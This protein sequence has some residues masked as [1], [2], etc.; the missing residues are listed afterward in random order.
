MNILRSTSSS[1]SHSAVLGEK[2]LLVLKSLKPKETSIIKV[3]DSPLFTDKLDLKKFC[4]LL[5]KIASFP[6]ILSIIRQTLVISSIVHMIFSLAS[7]FLNVP[8]KII[9]LP[10]ALLVY[11]ETSK[12][13]SI[14]TVINDK[15]INI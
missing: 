12:Y 2:A 10:L 8:V 1:E 6:E 4:V 7:V 5:N 3:R 11:L 14:H 13:I 15:G 9:L